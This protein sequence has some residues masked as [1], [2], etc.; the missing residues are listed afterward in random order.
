MKRK[1]ITFA[2]KVQSGLDTW[3]IWMGKTRKVLSRVFTPG[4][5]FT[6]PAC[7]NE[8]RLDRSLGL[9]LKEECRKSSENT[10]DR[11]FE[12]RWHRRPKTSGFAFVPKRRSSYLAR[13]IGLKPR[14]CCP[15]CTEAV[16]KRICQKCFW[17]IS[18]ECV[19]LEQNVFCLLG[20][21]HAG[22]THYLATLVHELQSARQDQLQWLLV[23]TNDQT[24][25]K[26]HSESQLLYREKRCLPPTAPGNVEPMIP[27]IYRVVDPAK[28]DPDHVVGF[29][30]IAGEDLMSATVMHDFAKFL[31]RAKGLLFFI[32][33]ESVVTANEAKQNQDYTIMSRFIREYP[34]KI[35]ETNITVPVAVVLSK[36]D[37]VAD[38]R[39]LL[40]GA[41]LMRQGV[42]D[43]ATCRKNSHGVRQWL[44]SR[45]E[46]PVLTLV[47]HGFA[48]VAYF[49]VSALG[50][51]PAQDRSIPEVTPR[52]I[53]DPLVW[54][55]A[56]GG[57]I[58]N[59]QT[60]H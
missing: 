57:L 46:N 50:N 47:E 19:G 14:I 16:G 25:D 31:F 52:R 13:L 53:L 8:G 43:E 45:H 36:A 11:D 12:K 30:D 28:R 56:M 48:N 27:M 29:Y 24:T 58:P 3:S 60:K 6:C 40:E 7:L 1:R 38:L 18:A 42:F 51:Q 59:S 54:L 35:G 5:S 23:D 9:C 37:T 49:A 10:F 17:E 39:P 44:M 22:K 26:A 34:P 4:I 2:D 55:L 21:K 41:S 32:D 15:K 33:A 20:Q